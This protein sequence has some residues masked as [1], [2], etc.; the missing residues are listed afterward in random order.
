MQSSSSYL[1]AVSLRV[2]RQMWL[3]QRKNIAAWKKHTDIMMILLLAA[4]RGKVAQEYAKLQ[5]TESKHQDNKMLGKFLTI[6]QI[7]TL[8]TT[9]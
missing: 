4:G 2:A 3:K 8:A 5:R 7:K 9:S 1:I 6:L